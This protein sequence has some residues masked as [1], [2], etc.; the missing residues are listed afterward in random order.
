MLGAM[1]SL[2]SATAV[3]GVAATLLAACK[4]PPP[5]VKLGEVDGQVFAAAADGSHVYFLAWKNPVAVIARMPLGGGAIEQLAQDEE[6]PRHIA[7]TAD[8]VYWTTEANLKRVPKSGGKPELFAAH[9]VGPIAADETSLYSFESNSA[10]L[11]ARALSGAARRVIREDLRCA[12][13]IALDDTSVYTS[14]GLGSGTVE[15]VSKAGGASAVLARTRIGG[16]L[17]L[18]GNDVYFCNGELYRVSKKGGKAHKISAACGDELAIQ[19]GVVYASRESVATGTGGHQRGDVMTLAD[20]ESARLLYKGTG[21]SG[22]L[23]G[24]GA[25]YV[26]V[27]GDDAPRTTW[28]RLGTAR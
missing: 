15:R 18:A 9:V 27:R 19:N 1:S 3:L 20:G 6:S 10:S 23:A 11:V 28:L 5:P 8:A 16:P 26:A 4:P 7:L 12:S 14:C 25:V 21:A 2:R 13:F 22:L 24:G 17:Q